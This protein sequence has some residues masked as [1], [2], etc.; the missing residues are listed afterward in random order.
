MENKDG[1]IKERLRSFINLKF[2]GNASKL[3]RALDLKPAHLTVML[4]ANEKGV[5]TTFYKKLPGL[6]LNLN[7]LVTGEGEMSLND[8]S[9]HLK[10]ECEE[11]KIRL[12]QAEAVIAFAEKH[13]TSGNF[14]EK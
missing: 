5:S 7:W 3:A 13:L 14:N 11:I 6:G 9:C 2:D 1:E 8:S 12:G 10:N 4:G